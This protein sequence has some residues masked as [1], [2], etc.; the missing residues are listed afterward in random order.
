MVN[1]RSAARA[2]LACALLGAPALLARDKAPGFHQQTLDLPGIPAAMVPA[3]MDGDG[4]D[5]L[6]VLVAYTGWTT[7]S[8]F[9]QARFD[10]IE[11]LVEV[12]NVVD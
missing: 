10:G 3:D 4:R 6:V 1:G 5:D 2:L 9:E 8:E 7:R 11:G 12:M